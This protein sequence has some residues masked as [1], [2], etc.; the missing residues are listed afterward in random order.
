MAR[1][2]ALLTVA[3]YALST[4]NL[5]LTVDVVG[6]AAFWVASGLSF[7]AFV[8]CPRRSWP[9]LVLGVFA[10]CLLGNWQ[11]GY[12]LPISSAMALDNALEPAIGATLYAALRGSVARPRALS[13]VP[14][15]IAGVGASLFGAAFGAGAWWLTAGARFSTTSLHWLFSDLVGILSIAPLLLTLREPYSPR[16]AG[17][18]GLSETLAIF[19]GLAA[20]IVSS[21]VLF[22]AALEVQGAVFVVQAFL[23][24]GGLRLRRREAT[25][26]VALLSLA[27]LF[28]TA[29]GLGPFAFAA[30]TVE[31]RFIR[32]QVFLSISAAFYLA[33]FD[34]VQRV[35]ESERLIKRSRDELRQVL[36]ASPDAV[37][38]HETTGGTIIDVNER[39]LQMY[40]A[41]RED[42]IGKHPGMFSSGEAQFDF[43]SAQDRLS[44]AEHGELPP[45]EWRA[46]RRDRTEF[47]A[48][49][50]LRFT[51]I[52]GEPRVIANVRDVD[53]RKQLEERLRHAQKLEVIGRLTGGIV[54]DFRNMVM[55]ITGLIGV[56]KEEVEEKPEV[57]ATLGMLENTTAG[58]NDLTEKLL[59]FSRKSERAFSN[60]SLHACLTETIA[61]LERT[62]PK[63]V[64][65]SANLAAQRQ[66]IEGDATTL[67]NAFLNLAL[68]ARDAMPDGGSLMISTK[69]LEL[70]QEFCS[71]SLSPIEPGEFVEVTFADEGH[72]IAPEHLTQLFQP[73]FT[74]KE[75][76]RGTG[77][78]LA[79]V[80]SCM[81]EHR[82]TVEVETSVGQGTVIHLLF[83]LRS[84]SPSSAP[85]VAA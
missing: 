42:L 74:T 6:L 80:L 32:L 31:G 79:S 27:I 25:A 44:Q 54:H 60:I 63:T 82:G 67:P 28:V 7:A 61:L 34:T 9:G 5:R 55:A 84:G 13:V 18:A 78:G 46:K 69:N 52:G 10:A 33:L 65:I 29:F 21:F 57:K 24:W 83:P 38:V 37:F 81:Q 36:D 16:A 71:R 43:A 77:L 17:E 62:L 40:R 26:L 41:R 50:A 19:A 35:R 3:Y 1:Q 59:S 75:N 4:L 68:N 14:L 8:V 85:T 12:P 30:P 15:M 51:R 70:D 2:S 76:S 56:L 66:Q 20:A 11:A 23:L 73:F 49:V 45:F 72:G 64:A 58:A 47:W 39:A 48:E 22:P 53:R